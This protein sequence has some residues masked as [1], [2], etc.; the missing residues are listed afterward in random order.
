MKR[1][2]QKRVPAPGVQKNHHV[3]AAY[4]WETDEVIWTTS[5]H[6]D[7]SAFISFLERLLVEQ[8]PTG[9]C[10]LVLDNASYHTSAMSRAALSL[11]EHRVLVM[12]LPPYCALELNPIERY[13][14]HM[15]DQVCINKLYPSLDELISAVDAELERQNDLANES[16]FMFSKL[17]L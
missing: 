7:S 10:V 1:G 11:F 2:R 4:D 5:A 13:W 9:S 16:R 6:K 12:W 14:R 3:F 15:K 8:H 17:E